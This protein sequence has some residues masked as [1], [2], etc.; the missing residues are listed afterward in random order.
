LP[1][2]RSIEIAIGENGL[3]LVMGRPAAA[4]PK[5]VI[6]KMVDRVGPKAPRANALGAEIHHRLR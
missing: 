3:L 5:T 6:G 4:K 2:S 1:K